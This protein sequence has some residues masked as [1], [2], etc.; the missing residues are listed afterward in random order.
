MTRDYFVYI[1][2]CRDG[3]L[4]TGIT[5]DVNRRV[6]EHNTS[7]RG[8]R[9]TRYRRPVK[10]LW[11]SQAVDLSSALRAEAGIKKKTRAQ[12]L[13]HITNYEKSVYTD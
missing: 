2:E 3:T 10:L 1:L 7:R 5:T 13:E 4:Y 11:N 6:Q 8:A 9:Y 12:K